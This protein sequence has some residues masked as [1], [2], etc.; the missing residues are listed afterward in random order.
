M[1]RAGQPSRWITLKALKVL[2]AYETS[3][4]PDKNTE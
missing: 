4:F 3:L 1:E 2:R